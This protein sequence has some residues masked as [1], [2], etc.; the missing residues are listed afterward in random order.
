MVSEP[1]R[2]W[3]ICNKLAN[4]NDLLQLD[5]FSPPFIVVSDIWP[6]GL[7]FRQLLQIA[8]VLA[9]LQTQDTLEMLDD[10]WF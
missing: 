6:L 2:S 9:K 10:I 5:D 7:Q 3:N 1:M 4:L 8:W